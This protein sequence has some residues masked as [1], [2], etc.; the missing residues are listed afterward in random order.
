M[1]VKCDKPQSPSWECIIVARQVLNGLLTALH[2]QLNHPSSHQLRLVAKHHLFCPEFGQCRRRY[3]PELPLLH[4]SRFVKL[5]ASILIK[6]PIL[7][8][9]LPV[10]SNALASWYLCWGS[11]SLPSPPSPSSTTSNTGPFVM[12]LFAYASLCAPSPLNCLMATIHTE[13]AP[14]F[15]V[16]VNDN[17][18]QHCCLTLELATPK[19]QIRILL[20][21]RQYRN[22]SM[23]CWGIP[24]EPS[25]HNSNLKLPHPF[26]RAVMISNRN[27]PTQ[28][29][30]LLSDIYIQPTLDNKAT[31]TALH[32]PSTQQKSKVPKANFSPANTSL[33]EVGDL[34]SLYSEGNTF[35]WCKC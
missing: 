29:V 14:G 2:I 31:L 5:F 19:T 3:N 4:C 33:V 28:P 17:I 34:V 22:L 30:Y 23:N 7:H 1:V 24:G 32:Q 10:F 9:L 15:I 20:L 16:L 18:L 25:N 26:S 35:C 8:P 21:N 11:V 12:P 27:V 6:H 13:P